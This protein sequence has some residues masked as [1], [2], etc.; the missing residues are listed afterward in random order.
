MKKFPHYVMVWN[1]STWN[2]LAKN[3]FVSLFNILIGRVQTKSKISPPYCSAYRERKVNNWIQL[4]LYKVF[5]SSSKFSRLKA[6]LC[7]MNIFIIP[8]LN[9]I[10]QDLINILTFLWWKHILFNQ[11]FV[12]EYLNMLCLSLLKPFKIY[13]NYRTSLFV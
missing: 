2:P 6:S 10:F 9:C 8:K 4:Y 12:H 5:F 13:E 3:A 11:Q 1:C 7:F